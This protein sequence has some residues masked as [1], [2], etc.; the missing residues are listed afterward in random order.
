MVLVFVE[1]Q[2]IVAQK[3]LDSKVVT[4]YWLDAVRHQP[5]RNTNLSPLWSVAMHIIRQETLIGSDKP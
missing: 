3:R 5:E 4:R 2:E 1:N